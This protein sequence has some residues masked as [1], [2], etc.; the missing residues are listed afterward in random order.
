MYHI[1]HAQIGFRE[2]SFSVAWQ[3]ITNRF[4]KII[5]ALQ[6]SR[7]REAAG[8]LAQHRNDRVPVVRSR[9]YL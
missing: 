8:I 3:G 6:E 1:Q 2:M 4:H 7:A 9:F 5:L